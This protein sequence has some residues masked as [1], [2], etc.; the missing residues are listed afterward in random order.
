MTHMPVAI[1]E[2]AIPAS[3]RKA[4]DE[5]LHI[6][7]ERTRQ[8]LVEVVRVEHETPVRGR[9]DPEVREVRITAQLHVQ[10]R[11][12][13]AREIGGRDVRRPAVEPSV[14]PPSIRSVLG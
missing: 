5:P 14:T 7:L 13:H 12:W 3:H 2:A 11:P 9:V 1:V 4:S 10:P 6:P 8:R